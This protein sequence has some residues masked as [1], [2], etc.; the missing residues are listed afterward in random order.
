MHVKYFTDEDECILSPC[1]HGG[2]C[3]N[4]PGSYKCNCTAGWQGPL[5]DSGMHNDKKRPFSEYL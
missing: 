1:F 4:L 5:C 2:L 3:V